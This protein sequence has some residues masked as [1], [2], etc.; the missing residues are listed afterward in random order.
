M[1]NGLVTLTDNGVVKVKAIASCRGTASAGLAATIQ[2]CRLSTAEE[3]YQ[4]AL[5]V[6]FGCK[7]CLVVRD[8]NNVIYKGDERLPKKYHD[9]K[10]FDKQHDYPGPGG[11]AE[12]F[13]SIDH[14]TGHVDAVSIKSE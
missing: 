8:A 1:S 7:D 6:G 14:P 9:K 12:Q 3:I 2:Q 11:F 4:A 5:A 13:A 10:S